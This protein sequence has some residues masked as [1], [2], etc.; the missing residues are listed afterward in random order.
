MKRT[1]A[2]FFS[3]AGLAAL[4][5]PN[6]A[7]AQNLD[8]GSVWLYNLTDGSQLVDDC[9]ICDRIPIVE[10]IRGTFELRLLENS[11][12]AMTYA[13]ENINFTNSGTLNRTYQV[14][15]N[16]FL[17]VSGEVAVKLNLYLEVFINNGI[18]NRLCYFDTNWAGFNHPWPMFQAGIDQTN[19]TP[20]QQFHLDL[21]A[22]PFREIW[23]STA[24]NFTAGISNEILSN[25]DLLS[26]KG[27]R[28]KAN[29]QLT[30]RFVLMPPA[31]DVGLKDFDILSGGEIV[32]S[33]EQ[34]VFSEKLGQ[35]LHAGDLL[36][37]RGTI[38][39]TNESFLAAFQ[40]Q[41]ITNAGLSA[42]QVMSAGETWFSVQTSFVSKALNTVIT[43]GDLLS[44]SGA[45]I[46]SN[47]QLLSRFKPADPSTN[48]GLKAVYVWP[49]GEIWFC[50]E[51]PFKG[52]DGVDYSPG[53]IL[54]DQGYV[55]LRNSELLAAFAPSTTTNIAADALWVV[56]DVMTETRPPLLGPP[57]PQ[58]SNSPPVATLNWFAPGRVFQLERATNVSGP[59]LPASPIQPDN[60]ATDAGGLTNSTRNFYRVRQ[61]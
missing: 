53:D 56:T 50:T 35:T 23:F 58:I 10:P 27:R 17:N 9:P 47:A 26:N 33:I 49:S 7:K 30:S 46:R 11:P 37:A 22:A 45:I 4:L 20:A 44:D 52:A 32:F 57:L 18:T 60:S 40:P 59:Y 48:A 6:T 54:S 12:L 38:L 1:F 36:S 34:D 5:G 61:W 29:T 16:G 42:V 14:T 15:G 13:L 24:S 39:R 25:G 43:P 41:S 2:F 55:V 8:A 3:L 21:N 51:S 19:G 31:P 28:V